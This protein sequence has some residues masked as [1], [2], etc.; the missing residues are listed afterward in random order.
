MGLAYDRCNRV[1]KLY[2]HVNWRKWRGLEDSNPFPSESKSSILSRQ[3]RFT[4]LL[5]IPRMCS[6]LC[7]RGLQSE[8]KIATVVCVCVRCK[9]MRGA[10]HMQTDCK[11]T[12]KGQSC[13]RAA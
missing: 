13:P 11:Q 7:G 9:G 3:P 1:W 5:L 4:K 12:E 8:A 10:G 6:A 2:E